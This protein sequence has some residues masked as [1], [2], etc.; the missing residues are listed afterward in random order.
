MIGYGPTWEV[1]STIITKL[2]I[3][4]GGKLTAIPPINVPLMYVPFLEK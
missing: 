4:D 1:G 3:L 2:G